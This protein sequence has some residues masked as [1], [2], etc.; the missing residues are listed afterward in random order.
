[1]KDYRDVFQDPQLRARGFF[2]PA[3]QPGVGAMDMPGPPYHFRNEPLGAWRPA[4]TLG[5]HNDE[6]FGDH[7]G[8]SARDRVALQQAGVI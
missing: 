3:E 4:P 8:V 6:V 2:V 5:E 1:M 7:L